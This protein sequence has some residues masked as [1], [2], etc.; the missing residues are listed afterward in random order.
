M[1]AGIPLR[2]MSVAY[3]LMLQ[4]FAMHRFIF[5]IRLSM[6]VNI[7]VIVSIVALNDVVSFKVLLFCY[8]TVSAGMLTLSITIDVC[9]CC[10]GSTIVARSALH[11]SL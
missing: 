2:P 4:H 9:C 6:V 10:Y 11:R 5:K 7:T 1:Q 3:N 8:W